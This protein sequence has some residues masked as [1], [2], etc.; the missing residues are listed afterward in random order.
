MKNKTERNLHWPTIKFDYNT[1]ILKKSTDVRIYSNTIILT[2]GE[3]TDSMCRMPVVYSEDELKLSADR[4]DEN[5]L[6]VDHC[7]DVQ[8]RIG[9]VKN[10]R[11]HKGAVR[12]DLHIFPITQT[13]KDTIAL[14]DAGLV[15]WLSAE[16][17]TQDVWDSNQNKRLA[18]DIE[19]IGCAVVL[20]PADSNTRINE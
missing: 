8:S 16:L 5:F 7:F 12:G 15:N 3:F 17:T 4:W 2:P 1:K 11:W 14:I 13:A 19:F 18:T 10:P 6:N 9:Y 20:Y